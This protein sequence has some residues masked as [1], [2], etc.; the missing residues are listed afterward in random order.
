MQRAGSV[1]ATVWFSLYTCVYIY[2]YRYVGLH[3]C[4]TNSLCTYL[5]VYVYIYI[6]TYI[7]IYIP[8]YTYTC[9]HLYIHIHIYIYIRGP[10]LG[11]HTSRDVPAYSQTSLRVCSLS[12]EYELPDGTMRT[13]EPVVNAPTAARNLDTAVEVCVK[14]WVCFMRCSQGYQ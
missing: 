5:C 1:Q 9:I 3:L 13:Y 2:M 11:A 12:A 4:I 7:H 8:M 6:Q 10:C 14:C